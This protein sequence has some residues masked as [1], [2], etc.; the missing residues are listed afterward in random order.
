MKRWGPSITKWLHVS[1]VAS[2]LAVSASTECKSLSDKDSPFLSG[3]VQL[4]GGSEGTLDAFPIDKLGAS[5]TAS[6]PELA[7]CVANVPPAPAM[8]S[9][10]SNG[11][12]QTC[13]NDLGAFSMNTTTDET[14]RSQLCPLYNKTVA[15]CISDLGVTSFLNVMTLSNGCCDD[16]KIKMDASVGA[17]LRT[18]TASMLEQIGNIACSTKTFEKS[19]A[20][21]SESCGWSFVNAFSGSDGMLNLLNMA[22]IPTDQVCVAMSGKQFTTSSGLTTQFSWS[23][24]SVTPIGICYKPV[25]RLLGI[26]SKLPIVSSW[27]VI[28]NGNKV[29][30]SD[31]F[32][33][34]KCVKASSLLAWTTDSTGFVMK[35]L[36]LVDDILATLGVSDTNA[37]GT[38]SST[39]LTTTWTETASQLNSYASSM[40]LHVATGESCSYSSSEKITPAF[41]AATSTPSSANS[42]RG[43]F[44][45]VVGIGILGVTTM[46][47]L[48]H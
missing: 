44:G 36:Q 7:K 18:L 43:S 17:D 31:F 19:G 38:T 22:Q 30:I 28:V 8:L 27:S 2:L 23:S 40:C 1:L 32:T 33:T 13:M 20:T 6:F 47:I 16:F 21:T 35:T 26:I 39:K 37:D 15:P 46:F 12:Y 9:V 5:V 14:I 48:G 3:L 29:A 10:T 11:N 41:Q 24:S 42:K 25:S 45:T 34:G 4:L